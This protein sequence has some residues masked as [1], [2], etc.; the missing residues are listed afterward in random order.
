MHSED[1]VGDDDEDHEITYTST[2]DYLRKDTKGIKPDGKVIKK[3]IS[4]TDDEAGI[5]SFRRKPMIDKDEGS[6]VVRVGAD[7][8]P[9]EEYGALAQA[10]R[11]NR[12][13]HLWDNCERYNYEV[14]PNKRKL[15][16]Y[17]HYCFDPI[18]G[19]IIGGKTPQDFNITHKETLKVWDDFVK[20]DD[21][22]RESKLDDWEIHYN[23]LT[24]FM[25]KTSNSIRNQSLA[26]IKQM[27]KEPES[28]EE[29]LIDD[30]EVD[31]EK[32]TKKTK[33]K[34]QPDI[35]PE[36]GFFGQIGQFGKSNNTIIVDDNEEIDVDK[37]TKPESGVGYPRDFGKQHQEIEKFKPCAQP[38]VD[39]T[40]S[41][42]GIAYKPNY[43]T[44]VCEKV[45]LVAKPNLF[46][47]SIARDKPHDAKE[48][49]VVVL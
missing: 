16:D 25:D 12:E 38:G 41:I 19:T 13:V 42:H 17:C 28:I 48:Y 18:T 5:G 2:Q 34:I 8:N 37:L 14:N 4:R 32:D 33:S 10:K 7:G 11:G 30:E 3:R 35:K 1:D 26:K 49:T 24:K 44:N 20:T 47:T 43:K 39:C 6:A 36:T 27:L 9:L 46:G 22:Y 15:D 31:S 40:Q 23:L 29:D 21:A 45:K